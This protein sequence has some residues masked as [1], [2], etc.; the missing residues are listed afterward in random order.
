MPPSSALI[1]GNLVVPTANPLISSYVV[2]TTNIISNGMVVPTTSHVIGPAGGLIMGGGF[3]PPHCNPSPINNAV[4]VPPIWP[5]VDY[6]R[7]TAEVVEHLSRRYDG[8]LRCKKCLNHVDFNGMAIFTHDQHCVLSVGKSKP[9]DLLQQK[10]FALAAR[11]PRPLSTVDVFKKF[12]QSDV[13]KKFLQS[14]PAEVR[15]SKVSPPPIDWMSSFVN[16]VDRTAFIINQFECLSCHTNGNIVQWEKHV[17]QFHRINPKTC[18]AELQFE[19]TCICFVCNGLLFGTQSMIE[20]H[21][22][23]GVDASRSVNISNVIA[24]YPNFKSS[25]GSSSRYHKFALKTASSASTNGVSSTKM[26]FYCSAC[27]FYGLKKLEKHFSSFEH[28]MHSVVSDDLRLCEVCQVVISSDALLMAVHRL[29]PSH[30]LRKFQD[31]PKAIDAWTETSVHQTVMESVQR[32]FG[33]HHFD[34]VTQRLAYYCDV[35]NFSALQLED[36]R[37]HTSS[38]QH[39]KYVASLVHMAEFVCVSCKLTLSGTFQAYLGHVT[40]IG[41]KLIKRAILSRYN[42]QQLKQP[43]QIRKLSASHTINEVAKGSNVSNIPRLSEMLYSA[44][45]GDNS[46]RR[47]EQGMNAVASAQRQQ[48]KEMR[49]RKERYDSETES[50]S[51]QLRKQKQRALSMKV[52]SESES[53]AMSRCKSVSVA[54]PNPVASSIEY[55]IENVKID[56]ESKPADELQFSKTIVK[57]M[58]KFEE[59]VPT[60]K[61]NTNATKSI[62][63]PAAVASNSS[64]NLHPSGRSLSATP[65]MNRNCAKSGDD[66]SDCYYDC[67]SEEPLNFHSASSSSD[68]DAEDA[69]IRGSDVEKVTYENES[70][71]DEDE[72]IKNGEVGAENDE[73]DEN[74]LYDEILASTENECNPMLSDEELDASV[75]KEL[76]NDAVNGLNGANV[77]GNADKNETT[78]DED[79]VIVR[80]LIVVR[81]EIC[82]Y[83]L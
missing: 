3:V 72:K 48:V 19:V 47:E 50:T 61:L 41:H 40:T 32:R 60:T 49:G 75:L 38:D 24:L 46:E 67:N 11:D 77:S 52:R 2:P 76:K 79:R 37:T 16:K 80:H 59:P 9:S 31:V 63:A 7:K 55:V 27:D 69:E 45:L 26:A 54:E 71:D 20:K 35:C 53:S 81:G 42:L 22:H 83:I 44:V 66:E 62:F 78:V 70:E 64:Q 21:T 23:R 17:M 65:T 51:T 28:N 30:L 10:P 68:R 82:I 8:L 13:F 58:Q 43:P 5:T 39:Q 6:S 4:S 1:S 14:C 29:T 12:L 34:S 33:E 15:S 73:D 57:S 36:W 56:S 18:D 25:N 74:D